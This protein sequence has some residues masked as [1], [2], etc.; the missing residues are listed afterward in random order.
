MKEESAQDRKKS[1]RMKMGNGEK[2]VKCLGN[3]D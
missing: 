3:T 2:G 1:H